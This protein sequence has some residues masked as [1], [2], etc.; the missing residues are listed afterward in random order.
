[1]ASSVDLKLC[2]P[3]SGG[4]PRNA[5]TDWQ[6][7]ASFGNDRMSPGHAK[8]RVAFVGAGFISHIHAEALHRL[9]NAQLYAVIDSSDGAARAFAAKWGISRLFGSIDEAVR[10]GEVDCAHVLTPPE[11]HAAVA[12]PFLEAG[13]PAFI[14]KPL[15]I[16]RSECDALKAA[17]AQARA[18]L[19]VNHNFVHHPAFVRLQRVVREQRLGALRSVSCTY[20]MPLRQITNRQFTHWMF[21]KPVNILLEQA[22]HPLSQIVALAGPVKNVSSMVGAPVE[23]TSGIAVP[24]RC[25]FTLQCGKASAVL[26]WAVGESFPFW[27]VVAVCDD[28]V[29][30]ADIAYNRFFTY[31]RTR[32]I[33]ACDHCLSGLATAAQ[34]SWHACHNVAQYA[35]SMAR[36]SARND[37]FFQSMRDSITAFHIALDQST[38]VELDGSFGAS[39]VAICEKAAGYLSTGRPKPKPTAGS[40]QYDVLVLGGTG[41]IGTHVVKRLLRGGYRVGVLARSLRNLSQVFDD[42]RLC[43][44]QGDVRKLTDVDRAVSRARIVINLAHGGG[45]G[46]YSEIRSAMLGSAELVARACVTHRCERLVH[47]GSIAALFLGPLDRPVT[48]MTLPDPEARRRS[49]Y[50]RA[51]AECDRLLFSLHVSEGLPV[52]ILRPGVVVGEGGI[53][54]HSAL[55]TFNNEQHCIG[56]NSGRNPLPFVLVEDVAEA[57]FLA[58]SSAKA[59]GRSYNLVGDVRLSAREY[60]AELAQLLDRPIQYHPKNTHVLWLQELGKWLLK[61]AAGRRAALPTRR[62]LLSRGLNA[63]FDCSDAKNDLGWRPVDDR[64]LF[65]ERAIGVH[66]RP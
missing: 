51:K 23:F 21:D 24:T 4:S 27:Q 63:T 10:S 47:I 39:V 7:N 6:E 31:K 11:T 44:I 62:D 18:A 22:V 34:V 46:D 25:D 55:G 35:A 29:A 2:D 5:R 53:S 28:G 41:F 33:E 58:C 56:W 45:S 59:V 12:L 15:A 64:S 14:E 8:R 48:G 17:A 32:W 16:D 38:P 60:V 1:M 40:E 20:N 42:Q 37:P 26:Q 30:V 65:I 66:A 50:A 9:R 49:D 61:A 52:C 54:S 57:V 36:L 3:H 13:I 43:M 19:G